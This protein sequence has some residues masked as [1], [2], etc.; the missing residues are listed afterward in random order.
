MKGSASREPSPRSLDGQ[1]STSA[2]GSRE[3]TGAKEGESTQHKVTIKN[4]G[5]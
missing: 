5:T 1:S 4:P 3:E 2:P